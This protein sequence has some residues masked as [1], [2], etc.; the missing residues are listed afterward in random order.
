V[1][2]EKKLLPKKTDSLSDWYTTLIQLADLAEYGPSKGS[3]IIKPYGY[4]IWEL[5]QKALDDRFKQHGVQNGYFPLLIPM[6]FL[7]K[8]KSHVEGFAPELAVVTH[9]GGEKLE[10]SL[11]I[12]PT[13]ETIIYDSFSRWVQSW[14]DLPILFN[15][16]CN[17]LRWEK[18]TMPFLRTSEFLWQEGHTA[19][20][21]HQEAIELQKWAMDTYKAVYEDYYA[22]YGYVG[23]KSLSE[24]F[25]GA[26]TTLTIEHLMP[27]GKAL[28]SSTSHDLGQNFAKVFNVSFQDK[29]GGESFVWQTSWG[30]STRSI[31]GLILAHGDDNGLRL[32]PRLAPVQIVIVPVLIAEDLNQYA[33]QLAKDL[34]ANGLRVTVDDRDDERFGFKLNKWEVKGVPLRVEIGKREVENNQLT[35]VRRWDGRKETLGRDQF[36]QEVADRLDTI[37]K[38]MLEASKQFVQAHTK[39]VSKYDEFKSAMRASEKGFVEV[40]WEDNPEAEAKIKE[41]T[42]ATSRC[43]IGDE[44]GVDFYTG[45][46][47]R[48]RWIFG[49]S[50]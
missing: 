19:H 25:A 49:Q 5:A 22:L 15:Q 36:V 2:T 20:A 9:G 3:M 46:T 12:R 47:V 31:G 37:Q 43:R 21:T 28:Q 6:S 32:P 13:S 14:R 11:V 50:Y 42:K 10:E 30:L 7:E 24:R 38:E 1:A 4:A 35:V 41:A 27:S 18:R 23:Y 45:K 44:E 40:F 8:E 17:V 16:W 29:D 33:H 26:D 48:G 39:K 34:Q